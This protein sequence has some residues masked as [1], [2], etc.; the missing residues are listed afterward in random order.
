MLD[1]EGHK[2]KTA[3][4]RASSTRLLAE[5]GVQFEA[6]NGG[7]HLVVKH[8][9][10]YIDFWPGTGLW[11]VRGSTKRNRG[12]LRLLRFLGR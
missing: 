11:I 10:S 5:S 8:H 6:K 3:R 9:Q 4:N 7:A 1:P 12:V 2:L